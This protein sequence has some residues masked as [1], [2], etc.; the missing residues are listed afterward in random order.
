MSVKLRTAEAHDRHTVEQYVE[1]PY[2]AE[3]LIITTGRLMGHVYPN[4][5]FRCFTR[6]EGVG[7]LSNT[8]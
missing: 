3:Y 8:G 4:N 2:D 5:L 1:Y 6:G 7:P